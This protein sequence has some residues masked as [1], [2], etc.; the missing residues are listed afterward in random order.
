MDWLFFKYLLAPRRDPLIWRGPCRSSEY[1][2]V[3]SL[4]RLDQLETYLKSEDA[5]KKEPA[6]WLEHLEK[7]YLPRQRA[8]MSQKL[9]ELEQKIDNFLQSRMSSV[10]LP[11]VALKHH[12]HLLQ[13]LIDRASFFSN[14]VKIKGLIVQ[15]FVGCLIGDD[16]E[17]EGTEN[18]YRK[19]HFVKFL[20]ETQSKMNRFTRYQKKRSLFRVFRE[21]DLKNTEIAGLL[22]RNTDKYSNLYKIGISKNQMSPYSFIWSGD[23][24]NPD[25]LISKVEEV[26]SR[27]FKA[28]MIP[29]GN[30]LGTLIE[31]SNF[32]II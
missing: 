30:L 8:F 29:K 32:Q 18:V 6:E 14:R 11:R 3:S 9:S 4:S 19:T 10:R 28:K 21:F 22:L 25:D 15:H 31:I 24:T 23:I 1:T 17:H 20:A 26:R 27:N 16:A 2:T 13:F 5:S 12:S 7:E